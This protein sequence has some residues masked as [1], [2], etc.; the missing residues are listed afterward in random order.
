VLA[1]GY[2]SAQLVAMSLFGI[3]AWER[4]GD[5]FAVYFRLFARLSPL[6][7]RDCALWVRRPLEDAARFSPEPGTVALICAAIGVTTFDGLSAGPVWADA[8][9]TIQGWFTGMG[10]SIGDALELA[11][12]VGLLVCVA[13]IAGGFRLAS[14][15]TAT[16]AHSL[17]PIA[18]AYVVAHYATLLIF[19]GQA[20]IP[21][22]SDPLGQGWNWL[23]TA[24]VSVDYGLLGASAIWFIQ[25]A[26]IVVGHVGGLALAHDRALALHDDPDEAARSQRAMLAIM[27]GLTSLALW[28]ISAS[29]Q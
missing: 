22:A 14:G 24:T 5:G 6:R 9:P 21:L 16:Y 18:L 3:D 28:L 4:R 11:S 10:L 19:Q 27:I 26:A 29:N 25:V 13:L 7:W 1:I 20:L 12:T 15:A 23:G 17:I 8:V 2:G